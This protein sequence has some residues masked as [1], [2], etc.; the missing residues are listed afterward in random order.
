MAPELVDSWLK[1]AVEHYYLPIGSAPDI[2][3]AFERLAQFRVL[4]YARVG[5]LGVEALNERIEGLLTRR[6]PAIKP[7]RHYHGCPIM[8]TRNHH[9]LKVY[10]GDVGLACR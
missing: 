2:K 7:G 4:V 9:G 6:I 1:Q 3:S 8:I 10:N 5:H